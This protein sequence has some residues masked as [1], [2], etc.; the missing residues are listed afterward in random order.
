M[1]EVKETSSFSP[2]VS[3]HGGNSAAGTPL[4]P[5]DKVR[6]LALRQLD[7]FLSL[8][9][10]VLA[11]E[12]PEAIHSLRVASRRLQQV[13]DLL[14]P[15]PRPAE[16]RRLRR[17]IRRCRRALGELRNCDVLLAR[18]EKSLARKRTARRGSWV[19]L[20]HYL[21]ERRA[22]TFEKAI[23]KLSRVNLGTLYVRLRG[24]LSVNGATPSL[25]H[26]A[27]LLPQTQVP[28]NFGDRIAQDLGR[29]WQAFETQVA[30]SHHD[31]SP[32]RIHGVRIAS[33]RLRYLVEVIHAFAVQGSADAVAW[34]RAL[35]NALGEWNDLEVLERTMIE[36]VARPQF[37]RDQLEEAIGVERLILRVRSVKKGFVAKYFQ[38]TREAGEFK[39]VKE[40]AA[41]LVASPPAAFTRD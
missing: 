3:L 21:V 22:Q 32:S 5:W 23:R 6:E 26:H 31:S 11:D 27:S 24:W 17:K 28:E 10:K 38:M 15:A 13:L 7:R 36:M 4:E 20:Q 19:A 30:Q 34:L 1:H 18:V 39:R 8:E 33:K 25:N 37:L 2:P 40:W 29:F 16:I 9:P 14:Y 12:S 35:Q 41:Y